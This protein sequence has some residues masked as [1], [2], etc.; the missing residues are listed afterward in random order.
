MTN[1]MSIVFLS[2]ILIEM[3]VLFLC[4][5][6]GMFFLRS[7][8]LKLLNTR[9]EVR[10]KEYLF[11]I[12]R[13]IYLQIRGFA[14]L[15]AISLIVKTLIPNLHVVLDPSPDRH[16]SEF[17]INDWQQYIQYT[18]VGLSSLAIVDCLIASCAVG[19]LTKIDI[20]ATLFCYYV[21]LS[22]FGMLY[23]LSSL[24]SKDET[25]VTIC[26]RQESED[27]SLGLSNEQAAGHLF[28]RRFYFFLFL[29]SLCALAHAGHSHLSRLAAEMAVSIMK[30]SKKEVAREK[31]EVREPSDVTW[32]HTEPDKESTQTTNLFCDDENIRMW[33]KYFLSSK[34]ETCVLSIRESFCRCSYAQARLYLW[35]IIYVA[36][37][38]GVYY[39]TE[40]FFRDTELRNFTCLIFT[41]LLMF[42]NIAR[43]PLVAAIDGLKEEATYRNIYN[44]DYTKTIVQCFRRIYQKVRR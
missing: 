17:S 42:N 32:I 7:T 40:N 23:F 27:Q 8:F 14:D 25:V 9:Q 41:T 18:V 30:D 15:A 33:R 11:L 2:M 21:P 39:Y 19:L 31:S 6:G 36:F 5:L 1:I 16:C 44:K 38:N 13:N 10:A 37:T 24:A 35:L 29:F 4:L 28:N 22:I 3:I 20:L 26:Y 12:N 43:F 34:A